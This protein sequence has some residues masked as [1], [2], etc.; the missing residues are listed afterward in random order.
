MPG[1]AD[2]VVGLLAED[3]NLE[4]NTI[5]NINTLDNQD[6]QGVKATTPA[7]ILCW[8]TVLAKR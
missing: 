7:T 8:F 2:F 1:A 4:K 5:L 6:I 3:V